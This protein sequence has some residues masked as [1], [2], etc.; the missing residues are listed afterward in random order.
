IEFKDP[1]L[2]I[3]GDPKYYDPPY[4]Y[5]NLGMAGAALEPYSQLPLQLLTGN[6]FKGVFLDEGFPFFDPPY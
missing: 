4:G 2:R 1:W 6:Y 3:D 5:R